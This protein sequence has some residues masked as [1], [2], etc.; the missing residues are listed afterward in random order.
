MGSQSLSTTHS[1]L[2][3]RLKDAIREKHGCEALYIH[4]V[5][6]EEHAWDWDGKVIIFELVGHPHAKRCVAW[7]YHDGTESRTIAM[8]E[9]PPVASPAIAVKIVSASGTNKNANGSVY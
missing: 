7:T 8:L 1:K 4:T 6:V 3:T 2:I 5:H 9:L